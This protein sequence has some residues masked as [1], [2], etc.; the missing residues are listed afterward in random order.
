M[1][2][3]EIHSYRDNP[4]E[5]IVDEFENQLFAGHP[6]GHFI[7]GTAESIATIDRQ[8]LL[9]FTKK[10]YCPSRMVIASVAKF[11]LLT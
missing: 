9:Y 11:D 8:D 7:L 10:H 6:L 3:D 4:A 1:V 5:E 2:L